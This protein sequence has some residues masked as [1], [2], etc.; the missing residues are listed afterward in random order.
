MLFNNLVGQFVDVGIFMTLKTFNTIQTA[1]LLD[2]NTNLLHV[3]T[4]HLIK[5][6]KEISKEAA[7]NTLSIVISD[8]T[9]MD[10][11]Q[12]LIL[13]IAIIE[14]EIFYKQTLPS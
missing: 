4:C 1:T 7:W 9:T 12:V 8:I 3:V 10:I 2:D 5:E 14:I 6:E 13:K 11:F